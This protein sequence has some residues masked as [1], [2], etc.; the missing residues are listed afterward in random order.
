MSAKLI[1]CGDCGRHV[2]SVEVDC[3]FCGGVVDA[4]RAVPGRAPRRLN[5]AAMWAFGAAV[6]TSAAVGCGESHDTDAGMSEP[7]TGMIDAGSIAQPYGA[8]IEDAGPDAGDEADAG[9]ETDAGEEVDAG[10]VAP[11][12]GA[13]I[14]DAGFVEEDAGF[15]PLYGGAPED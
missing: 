11:P 12:Y 14:Q 8:P 3:P 5:R 10:N 2:M 13:P 7:D 4:G 9:D 6:A 1:P 15:A